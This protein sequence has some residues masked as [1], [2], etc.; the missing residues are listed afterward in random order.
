MMMPI[1]SMNKMA[2]N[3]SVATT[4][5]YRQVPTPTAV[6]WEVLNGGWIGS[7]YKDTLQWRDGYEHLEDIN[8]SA[9]LNLGYDL[10]GDAADVVDFMTNNTLVYGAVNATAEPKYWI[11]SVSQLMPNMSLGTQIA[12]VSGGKTL[13]GDVCDHDG[14]NCNYRVLAAVYSENQHFESTSKHDTGKANWQNPHDAT[15]FSS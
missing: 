14:T 4:C 12:N 15:Q 8:M 11:N 1:V 7:G 3:E 13:L 10:K 6:Y 2:M 9:W 5:C